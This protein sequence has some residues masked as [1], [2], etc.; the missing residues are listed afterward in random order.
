MKLAGDYLF[1]APVEEVW[2]ALF[3]PEILAA[4]MP[5]CEKLERV[6]GRYRGELNVKVGPVQGK[7]SGTVDL[8]DTD[9][10]R[11]YTM[12]IDGRGAP[13]FVKAKAS[14]TLEG[15]GGGTRIRYDADAQVGGKVASVG[16]RLL[17]ASA[18]AIVKQSLEGLHE[19]IK[20]RAAAHRAAGQAAAAPVEVQ[21]APTTTAGAAARAAA[22][23]DA[24]G[25][26]APPVPAVALKHV[27][28]SALAAS[29]AQEVARSLIPRP[30]LIGI[31]VAIAALI[32]WLILRH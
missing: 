16:Q 12:I 1:D 20:I 18:R 14:V 19:N 15:E 13:G 9:E 5:G 3:D 21:P 26:Q 17:E 32:V 24:P 28:Q 27:S 11:S 10:P 22:A 23:A 30:V 6:D 7:F 25:A 2:N 29:V 4:V 31:A 8:K